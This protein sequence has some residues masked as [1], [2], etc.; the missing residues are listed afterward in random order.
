VG[1]VTARRRAFDVALLLVVPVLLDVFLLVLQLL[2]NS[3]SFDLRL[4]YIPAAEDVLRGASP[5]P[6]L[7]DAALAGEHAY[8]YPPLLAFL[9]TPFTLLPAPAASVVAVLL[10]VAALGATLHLLGVRD[11]RCYGALLAWGPVFDG[12]QV[13]SVSVA[14]ALL[15]ALAW[16]FRERGLASGSVVGLV[17]ALKLFLWPLAVWSFATGR[18]RAALGAIAVAALAIFVPWGAVGFAGLTEYPAL[19]RK[20]AALEQHEGFS[21][22]SAFAS[23]GAS[24]AAARALALALGL[25]LLLGCARAGRRGAD[26][27]AFVLA[28]AAALA[29]TPIAWQ[30]YFVV[31]AV[32]LAVV[33]PRFSAA[34]LIP[35]VG[36]VGY[37]ARDEPLARSATVLAAAGLV[38][39]LVR[40]TGERDRRPA[41]TVALRSEGAA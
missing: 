3:Y 32:P 1:W 29:L 14:L 31:L 19:L 2:R 30:H 41:R 33:R 12:L 16:R 17:V 15:V 13:A 37:V 11:W 34:W 20:L 27:R 25:A 21:L 8:V 28:L 24:T 22:V 36:W 7:H 23:V 26:A 9:V 6:G 40:L 10:L 5:Y 38:V 39:L 18:L 35:V 4:A